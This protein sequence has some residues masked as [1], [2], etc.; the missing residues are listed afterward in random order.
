MNAPWTARHR[1]ESFQ[2]LHLKII[3]FTKEIVKIIPQTGIVKSAK[4]AQ[5]GRG[6]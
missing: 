5:T 4:R 2:D 3:D 1:R 6:R